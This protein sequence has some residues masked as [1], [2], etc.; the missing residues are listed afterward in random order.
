M[1]EAEAQVGSYD[2]E[3]AGSMKFPAIR[4]NE[5]YELQAS[6]RN[7]WHISTVFTAVK[8]SPVPQ[9]WHQGLLL[10]FGIGKYPIKQR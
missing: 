1:P 9:R 7:R 4:I 6:M 5:I 10:V 2:F 3:L 8:N